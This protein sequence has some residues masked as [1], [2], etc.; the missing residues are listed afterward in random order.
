MVDAGEAPG[1]WIARAHYTRWVFTPDPV[2]HTLGE[3]ELVVAEEDWRVRRLTV[4]RTWTRPADAQ[5]P[6][7]EKEQE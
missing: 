5:A 1:S 4:T 7:D 3:Y 2:L 6:F